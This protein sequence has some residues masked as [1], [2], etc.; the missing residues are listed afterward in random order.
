MTVTCLPVSRLFGT[1]FFNNILLVVVDPN[2]WNNLLT[3]ALPLLVKFALKTLKAYM[4]SHGCNATHMSYVMFMLISATGDM[5]ARSEYECK[6]CRS[7]SRI[8]L[9]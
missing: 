6:A 1:P 2:G 4:H 7:R 9:H 8:L 5:F 3:L